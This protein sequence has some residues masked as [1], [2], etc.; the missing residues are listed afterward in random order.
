M[1]TN[2]DFEALVY[3]IIN[4]RMAGEISGAVYIGSRPLN[5]KQEDV[6]INVLAS[7]HAQRQ[8]T[9]INVNIFVPDIHDGNDYWADNDRMDYLTKIVFELLGNYHV[10]ACKITTESQ[11]VFAVEDANNKQ[12]FSNIKILIKNVN[13]N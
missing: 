10:N 11:Q 12:H 9:A 3:E 13:I 2:Y 4:D 5:S 6:T 7:M 8:L 1:K